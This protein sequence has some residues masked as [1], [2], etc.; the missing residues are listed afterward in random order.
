MKRLVLLNAAM[1]LLVPSAAAQQEAKQPRKNVEFEEKY[2]REFRQ[3]DPKIGTTVPDLTA[4]DEQGE[5]FAWE[6]TRGKYTV[7]VFGCL[8]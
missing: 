2:N 1:L 7:V 4:F 8:T 3:R 5:P 6:S